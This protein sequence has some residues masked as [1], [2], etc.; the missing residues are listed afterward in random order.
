[1]AIFLLIK[2]RAREGRD[3]TAE[4]GNGEKSSQ[5]EFVTKTRKWG[6]TWQKSLSL[7]FWLQHPQFNPHSQERVSPRP[8]HFLQASK[9]GSFAWRMA[10]PTKN[11]RGKKSVPERRCQ[12][13]FF[14]STSDAKTI[15]EIS[16]KI[17]HLLDFSEL[18][19]SQMSL[20]PRLGFMQSTSGSY[21]RNAESAESSV[22]AQL[23][24]QFYLF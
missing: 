12:Q 7:I 15:Q 17:G 9:K 14:L 3:P 23:P 21:F 13:D 20:E 16:L 22:L 18:Q 10:L 8:P 11:R 4:H 19:D 2:K 5:C 1:M 24:P 6:T